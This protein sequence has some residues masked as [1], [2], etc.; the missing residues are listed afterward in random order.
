MKTTNAKSPVIQNIKQH[1]GK[2]NGLLI[3]SFLDKDIDDVKQR[4]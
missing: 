4:Q 1:Q 2:L 3:R